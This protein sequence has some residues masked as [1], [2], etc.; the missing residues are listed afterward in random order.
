MLV[1]KRSA[2]RTAPKH[3]ND[4]NKEK[5]WRKFFMPNSVGNTA[6]AKLFETSTDKIR[7][8]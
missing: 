5:F 6:L 1:E 3:A 8:L 2:I 7:L 4:P